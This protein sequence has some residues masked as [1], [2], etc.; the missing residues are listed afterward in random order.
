MAESNVNRRSTSSGSGR[1]SDADRYREAA[2]QALEM[3]DWCIGYLTG[4]R[5]EG[6]AAQLAKSRSHIR[7]RMREPAEP[8]PTSDD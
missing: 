4:C 6:I 8:V 3:I 2:T 5:K 7:K 1:G